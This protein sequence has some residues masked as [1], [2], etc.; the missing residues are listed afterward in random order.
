MRW[1]LDVRPRSER[2]RPHADAHHDS[3]FWCQPWRCVVI[4]RRSPAS[5]VAG[6]LVAGGVLLLPSAIIGSA[7]LF[8]GASLSL[9]GV[10]AELGLRPGPRY[11]ADGWFVGEVDGARV[12]LALV[13][14]AGGSAQVRQQARRSTVVVVCAPEL[15]QGVG[16][17]W[18]S[19]GGTEGLPSRLASASSPVGFAASFGDLSI[20]A[21]DVTAMVCG[22][23]AALVHGWGTGAPTAEGIRERVRALREVR[24]PP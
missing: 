22:E 14:G 6:C 9:E 18:S 1:R 7:F 12:G 13:V 23:G 21:D 5:L 16:A 4:H 24:L 11:G 17:A 8:V 20:R 2:P 15:E 3:L 10:A 19:R